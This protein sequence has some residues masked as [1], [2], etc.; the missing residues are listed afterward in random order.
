MKVKSKN[1]I[2]KKGKPYLKINLDRFLIIIIIGLQ[3]SLLASYFYFVY[4]NKSMAGEGI[5]D[6]L[7]Y[8]GKIVNSDG[9]PPPDGLYNLR[10]KIYDQAENGTLLWT[11][12]WDGTSQGDAGSKVNVVSGVFTVE[13]NSLCGSWTGSCASDGGVTFTTDSFYLQ[14]ELD[15][16]ADD[17]YEE[18]FLPRKRFTATPYA[19]NAE[20]IDGHDASE[21][22]FKEGDSMTGDLETINL[23]ADSNLY[24]NYGGSGGW[25]LEY[26]ADVLPASATPSWTKNGTQSESVSSG[27]LHLTDSSGSDA[28]YYTRAEANISSAVSVIVEARLKVLTNSGDNSPGINIY[29][30]SKIG[31]I[32][33]KTDK[34]E[35]LYEPASYYSIDMT[36][37]HLIRLVQL[38]SN[39]KVY[40]D[41]GGTAVLDITLTNDT[42]S[43]EIYFGHIGTTGTG[44]S[45]WDYVR[46][47]YSG[48][49]GKMYFS[50]TSGNETSYLS[51]DNANENFEFSASLKSL[52]DL[53]SS[54]YLK[55]TSAGD[56]AD[57]YLTWDNELSQFKFGSK[58]LNPESM[59][60]LDN[61]GNVQDYT[62][63]VNEN[64]ILA[65]DFSESS[66]DNVTDLAGNANGTLGGDASWVNAGYIG[67]G[68]QFDDDGDY[69]SFSDPGLNNDTG[70]IE[71]WVKL[72]DIVNSSTDYIIMMGESSSNRIAIYKQNAADL[73]V[74]VGD[75]GAIDT[76]WDFPDTNWHHIALIWN[77]SNVEFYVDGEK[78]GY[79]SYSNL[80]IALFNKFYIG[81]NATAANTSLNGYLDCAAI[82]NSTLLAT[83]YI[84]H[85][86]SMFSDL[87]VNSISDSYTFTTLGDLNSLPAVA[88]IVNKNDPVYFNIN[89]KML[90]LAFSEG[91][92][93]QTQSNTGDVWGTIS[94]N[95]HWT[96]NG[97]HG[98]SISFDGDDDIIQFADDSSFNPGY[99]DFTIEFFLNGDEAYNQS[100]KKLI[101]KRDGDAGFEIYFNE[102]NSLTYF[103]GDGTNTVTASASGGDDSNGEWEHYLIAFD[104]DGNAV[105]YKNGWPTNST[106]ISSVGD[107]ST[108]TDLYIG[109]DSSGNYYKGR[110]DSIIMYRYL[111]SVYDAYNRIYNSPETLIL[112]S[113]SVQDNSTN[114]ASLNF[115]T[116]GS[117]GIF[118]NWGQNNSSGYPLRVLNDSSYAIGEDAGYHLISFGSDLNN[119]FGNLSFENNTGQFI[120]DRGLWLDNDSYTNIFAGWTRIGSSSSP[121]ATLDVSG[122]IQ[123]SGSISGAI[124][125]GGTA[126][127]ASDDP[128][129]IGDIRYASGYIYVCVDT[130]SWQRAEMNGW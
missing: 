10:F 41:G 16:N 86:N 79:S 114:F 24:V 76:A 89:N 8:Q 35:Y 130:D 112:E 75:S 110:V 81:S 85:A 31:A 118:A 94:G 47:S 48:D 124:R 74:E 20:K 91:E 117:A 108:S 101:S 116:A 77:V 49:A 62:H 68:M 36:Q 27:I 39:L 59:P 9:V 103:I 54:N 128:C 44:E 92:G 125:L 37:Y 13:L 58:T 113:R 84:A 82:Y 122:D 42:S 109:G 28:I 6:T 72:N 66:G 2:L 57:A 121:G 4:R 105:I 29:N 98:F 23:K 78:I 26:T 100:G 104:R 55:F 70:S 52:G 5:R 115:S 7:T 106:S 87:Y 120:F 96:K 60:Y 30:G 19:M 34:I 11:E 111:G 45:Y 80:N 17:A 3:I 56:N 65:Y 46:Y 61:S 97:Y 119:T 88:S 83:D 22:I 12:T 107:I 50:G 99:D 126:P 95:A 40:V 51:Y 15:Y 33:F 63:Y 129:T 73:I 64:K 38:G 127:T 43:E 93:N 123:A 25:N 71:M 69:I 21:F 90:A 32:Q 1:K 67:Y 102:S 18:I 53:I 14:V